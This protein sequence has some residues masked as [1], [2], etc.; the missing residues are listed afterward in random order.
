MK[1]SEQDLIVIGTA[2]SIELPDETVIQGTVAEIG[3]IAV[4]PEGAQSGDPYLDVSIS[5]ERDRTLHKWTGAP[6]TVSVTAEIA[7][8]VL[9]APIPSLLALLDG[10]YALEIIEPET[11]RLVPIETGVYSEGWV[12]VIGINLEPGIS[13]VIPR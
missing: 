10:G 1:V 13:V 5:I 3:R 8:N 4:I 9:A 2:V 6:V 11:T 12:E 7:E